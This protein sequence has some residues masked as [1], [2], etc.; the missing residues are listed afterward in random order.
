MVV[1]KTDSKFQ[2]TFLIIMII[3]KLNTYEML[4]LKPPSTLVS[5][6]V[7]CY[8]PGFYGESLGSR[9]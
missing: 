1:P 5:T 2:G 7:R 4:L 9:R 3:L 6:N 8:Y